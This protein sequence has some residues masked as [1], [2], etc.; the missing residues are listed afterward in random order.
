MKKHTL[1]SLLL[2][3]VLTLAACGGGAKG[4][5]AATESNQSQVAPGQGSINIVRHDI[6]FGDSGDSATNPPPWTI[7]PGPEVS[8]KVDNEGY[9]ENNWTVIKLGEQGLDG[10][11]QA[12]GQDNLPFN[13]G[14]LTGRQEKSVD[15]A[16]SPPGAYNVIYTLTGYF[17]LVE[18]EPVVN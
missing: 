1:S 12:T 7:L 2:I 14:V 9:L 4:Q 11:N 6:N 8:I 18:R 16:A 3:T 13:I 5:S 15:F 10:S 17:P